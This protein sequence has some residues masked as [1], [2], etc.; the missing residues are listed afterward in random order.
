MQA[1]RNLNETLVLDVLGELNDLRARRDWEEH[2]DACDGCRRERAQMLQL[3]GKVKK[4]GMPPELPADR[5]AAMANHVGWRL[6]NERISRQNK[7]GRRLR[8]VPVLAAAC[9]LIVIGLAGYRMQDRFF[10]SG[11]DSDLTAGL[12]LPQQD[13][14]VIKHLDLLKDMDTIEK[15][16]HVVDPSG[17]GQTPLETNPETQGMQPNETKSVHA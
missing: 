14:E 17:N 2:L 1:C 7:A 15:L 13:L 9:A 3:L 10:G 4:A 5:A 8:L 6:G 11:S 16:V 12:Q